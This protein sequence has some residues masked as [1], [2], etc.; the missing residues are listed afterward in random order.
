MDRTASLGTLYN[1]F[2]DVFNG[3]ET[4]ETHARN[5]LLAAADCAEFFGVA[6]ELPRPFL[7]VMCAADAHPVC[8]LIERT[9]L[10]RGTTADIR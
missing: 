10:P 8:R 5:A 3:P 2:A 9:R 4:I 7:D 6:I 1:Q